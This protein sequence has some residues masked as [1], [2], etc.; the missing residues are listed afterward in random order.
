VPTLRHLLLGLAVALA[1]LPA[2][3]QPAPPP[4]QLSAT[5]FD[6]ARAL[7]FAPRFPLWSDGADKQRWLQ[8]PPDAFIDA[9]DP[10]AWV[11]P[12]GTK[13][14][15]QFSH[16]GRPVETRLIERRADGWHYAT[17]LWRAD[18]SEADLAPA[19]GIAALPLPAAPGGRYAVPGRGDCVS[20]HGGAT[21]PVLGLSA[22]QLAPAELRTLVERGQ[23]RGLPRNLVESPPHIAARSATESM[24]LGYLHGNCSH[25]HHPNPGRVPVALNLMQR[26]ADP[27]RSAAEVLS[28]LIESPLRW[29]PRD[30]NP[31][32]R[33]VV[34][35]DAAASALLQRMR[36][37]DGRTQMPP[38]GTDHP[39]RD[40]LELLARW[41]QN[42]P[43]QPK[44]PRP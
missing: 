2:R 33:A 12:V 16:G 10:D 36:A 6:A 21:V 15:K 43:P 23:L 13:L 5:G 25:C 22:L 8:L 7:P 44:E 28:T 31:N 42:L 34:P 3:A 1:L 18:G 32:A 19:R 29:Q 14:W 39:D 41:I 11:F 4:E 37:R 9:S 27:S 17:Y 40:A 30:E 20:C 35:G 26:A 24:A 38:L